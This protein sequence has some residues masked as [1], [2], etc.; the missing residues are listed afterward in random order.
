M[1]PPCGLT[2]LPLTLTCAEAPPMGIG[3]YERRLPPPIRFQR[4]QHWLQQRPL[5]WLMNQSLL[6]LAFFKKCENNWQ[7][8]NNKPQT[9]VRKEATQRAQEADR[10]TQGMMYDAEDKY[11]DIIRLPH[12]VSRTHP[13]MSM[14]NRAARFSPFAALTG[15]DAAIAEA[16]RLTDE[17]PILDESVKQEITDLGS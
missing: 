14:A 8:I 11:A 9:D 13:Q 4:H 5:A 10:R 16:T 7:F 3:A 2:V 12:H 6:R 1:L 17:R 15:H